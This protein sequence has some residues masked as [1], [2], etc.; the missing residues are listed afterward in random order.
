MDPPATEGAFG[1]AAAADLLKEM[2]NAKDAEA[3]ST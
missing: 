2:A 3:P 1:A